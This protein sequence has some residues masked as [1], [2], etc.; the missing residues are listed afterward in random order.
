MRHPRAI[1]FDF[2]TPLVGPTNPS[3]YPVCMSLVGGMDSLDLFGELCTRL[4]GEGV[5]YL[6]RPSP[7]RADIWRLLIRSPRETPGNYGASLEHLIAGGALLVAH[8]LAFEASILTSTGEIPPET[9]HPLI[10]SRLRCTMIREMLIAIAEGTYEYCPKLRKKPTFSLV[11]IATRNLGPEVGS[12]IAAD[13]QKATFNRDTG[14]FEVSGEGWRCRYAALTDIP[15]DI[16]PDRAIEYALTDSEVTL[17][18]FRVQETPTL[19]HGFTVVTPAGDVMDEERQSRAALVLRFIEQTGVHT[20]P[21]ASEDY[22]ASVANEV[23]EARILAFRG[24]FLKGNRCEVCY[25]TGQ[26]GEPGDYSICPVC[27]ADPEYVPRDRMKP[28]SKPGIHRG[29]QQA[30]ISRAYGYLPPMSDPSKKFPQGQIRYDTDTMKASGDALLMAY[31][32]TSDSLT[33]ASRYIPIVEGG[34]RFAIHPRFWP[35]VRSG[36]TS[37]SSPNYQ[38]PPRTRGF[39]EAHIAPEG[40]VFASLDY[41]ALELRTWA[42]TC[43]DLFG[44]SDMAI[45]LQAGIDPHTELALELLKAQGIK[46]PSYKN[47]EDILSTPSHPLYLTVYEARQDAKAGNFG[48]PGGLGVNAFVAWLAGQGRTVSFD[49]AAVI[50][51][52]WLHKWAESEDYFRFLR[53]LSEKAP[54]VIRSKTGRDIGIFT[55][56]QPYSDRVRGGVSY[57][58][59]ANTLFQGPAADGMKLALWALYREMTE[60]SLR[61]PLSGVRAWNMVHDEVI[62]V[63]PVESAHEW[64][65][66]AAE[67][68]VREMR[69]VTPDIPQIVSPELFFRWSKK[70]NTT[71]DR[72][73]RLIPCDDREYHLNVTPWWLQ[74]KTKPQENNP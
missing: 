22:R 9:I 12:D 2:E 14:D 55:V 56:L 60:P 23:E 63:G 32:E 50:R 19:V 26:V 15:L 28:L 70:T 68:M 53:D 39:R 73:G 66:R 46:A 74:K 43:L 36:R 29:R 59:A 21:G 64:A 54:S 69:R 61:S 67:V 4:A 13:K 34:F 71:R 11:D 6:S 16:W 37:C 3:P 35:L 38:N 65:T 48:F 40:Q 41:S 45:A 72:N 18:A 33:Q 51:D 24:G 20:H 52:A 30:A 58:S 1:G 8:N 17:D 49:K 27:Y 25:Q 62:F 31:A 7:G 10:G 47:A 5:D 42:Q 44:R 57:T